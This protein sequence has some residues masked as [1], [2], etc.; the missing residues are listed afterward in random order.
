MR[1]G[2][3]LAGAGGG[4]GGGGEPLSW[5]EQHVRRGRCKHRV[6][7]GG[8]VFRT[9]AS[10]DG[11]E[12]GGGGSYFRFATGTTKPTGT[13]VVGPET[14]VVLEGTDG[15]AGGAAGGA[16][17]SAAAGGDSADSLYL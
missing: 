4:G 2:G 14:V 13:V 16:E 10:G 12:G 15:A 8:C 11:G 7:R 1:L 3:P 5:L 17:G 6:A 9:A